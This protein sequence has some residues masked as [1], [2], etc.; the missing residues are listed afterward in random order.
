MRALPYGKSISAST[1]VD[2]VAKDLV[3]C[4]PLLWFNDLDKLEPLAEWLVIGCDVPSVL[5]SL[6]NLFRNLLSFLGGFGLV[7]VYDSAW[8]L[9]SD[10]TFSCC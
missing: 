7:L 5:W 2:R 8:S 1:P 9:R 4:P 10:D 3:E 6:V